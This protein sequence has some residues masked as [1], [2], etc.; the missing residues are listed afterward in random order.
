LIAPV[1]SQRH[2]LKKGHQAADGLMALF[3]LPRREFA[4]RTWFRIVWWIK[5]AE[6]ASQWRAVTV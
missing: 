5:I 6:T 3:C 4:S 2:L 1:V